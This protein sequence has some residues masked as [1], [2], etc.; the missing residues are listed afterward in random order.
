MSER[1]KSELVSLAK[2][3]SANFQYVNVITYMKEVI[4]LGF[5]LNMYERSLLHYS[6]TALKGPIDD[7]LEDKNINKKLPK[8]LMN[9]AKKAICHLCKDAIF[10]DKNPVEIDINKEAYYIF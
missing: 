2:N 6:F 4:R 9:N 3:C 1:M 7:I 10:L 5:P 8:E